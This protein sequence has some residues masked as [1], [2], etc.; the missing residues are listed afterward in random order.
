MIQTSW[1]VNYTSLDH[2]LKITS[3]YALSRRCG[4]NIR[5]HS[6]RLQE[7]TESQVQAM[8]DK[9]MELGKGREDDLRPVRV[10]QIAVDMNTAGATSEECNLLVAKTLSIQLSPSIAWGLGEI[11]LEW[12][13][14]GHQW[15][16]FSPAVVFDNAIKFE[17]DLDVAHVRW[18]RLSVITGGGS[19]NLVT[20]V[21][22]AV[23]HN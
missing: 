17:I 21:I 2:G 20:A 16:S 6:G 8:E 13:L 12:T 9:A 3:F 5:M 11:G 15:N 14:D 7:V 4:Y 23:L 10:S 18:V 22:L 19:P 1:R